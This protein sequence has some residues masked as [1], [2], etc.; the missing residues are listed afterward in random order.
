MPTQRASASRAC[1]AAEL[2]LLGDRLEARRNLDVLGQPR[3]DLICERL[4]VGGE[5]EIHLEIPESFAAVAHERRVQVRL[6][7]VG[8]GAELPIATVAH[9]A[10]VAATRSARNFW[11]TSV[12]F[13]ILFVPVVGGSRM[14]R[15]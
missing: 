10:V 3:A 12:R 7:G 1:H 15:T 14:M 4:L 6:V 11:C 9:V 8:E 13:T 2:D 5:R